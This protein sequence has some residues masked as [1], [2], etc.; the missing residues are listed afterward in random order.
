[1]IV[2]LNQLQC[3]KAA[4][5][6]DSTYRYGNGNFALTEEL[7][8]YSSERFDDSLS[9]REREKQ[10]EIKGAFQRFLIIPPS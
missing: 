1:M 4:L 8:E 9:L 5:T 6:G 10:R 7:M 3:G 2:R